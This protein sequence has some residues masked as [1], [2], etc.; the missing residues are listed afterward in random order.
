MYLRFFKFYEITYL[1]DSKR[2]S[3]VFYIVAAACKAAL[4]GRYRIM[5]LELPWLYDAIHSSFLFAR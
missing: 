5:F 2:G 1:D 3:T 4:Q